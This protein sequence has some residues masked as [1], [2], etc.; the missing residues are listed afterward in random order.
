M[1]STAVN[2]N[3]VNIH[4]RQCVECGGSLGDTQVELDLTRLTQTEFGRLIYMDPGITFL[5]KYP[6]SRHF[7]KPSRSHVSEQVNSLG[8][9]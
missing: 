1:P 6:A 4:R 3:L 9:W 2:Q 5:Q 7:R 8:P